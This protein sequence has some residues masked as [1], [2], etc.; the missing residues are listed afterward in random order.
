MDNVEKR[1]FLTLPGLNSDPS[2]VQP[3]ASRYTDWAIPD[4]QHCIVYPYNKILSRVW[5]VVSRR[6]NENTGQF[7]TN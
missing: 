2:V 6:Y 3:V 4:L 1:E 5:A 7:K